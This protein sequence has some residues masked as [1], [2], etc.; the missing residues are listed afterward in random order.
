MS[1][2]NYISKEILNNS[3]KLSLNV[4]QLDNVTKANVKQALF[5]NYLSLEK[6][7]FPL[8]YFIAD[9]IEI[10]NEDAWKWIEDFIANNH[11]IMFFEQKDDD[12]FLEFTNGKDITE[13]V[14]NSFIFTF[15]LTN[16][17]CEYLIAYNQYDYLIC[18]GMAE[19]WLLRYI[20][21]NNI[22]LT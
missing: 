1:I 9:K 8:Y 6:Y 2:K 18:A 5:K 19:E 12:S 14:N 22:H 20:H 4:T 15:Y 10:Q 13:I 7:E 16:R 17:N 3:N 21:A 11:S